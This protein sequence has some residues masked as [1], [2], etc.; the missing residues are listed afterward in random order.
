MNY[1]HGS[2]LLETN[3]EILLLAIKFRFKKKSYSTN[4][5]INHLLYYN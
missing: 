4:F 1:L 2:V 5:D 3:T